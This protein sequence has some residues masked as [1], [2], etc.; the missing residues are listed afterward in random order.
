[1][2]TAVASIFGQISSCLA[3]AQ[4]LYPPLA[5]SMPAFQPLPQVVRPALAEPKWRSYVHMQ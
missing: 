2:P 1:M 3:V 4:T 5:L